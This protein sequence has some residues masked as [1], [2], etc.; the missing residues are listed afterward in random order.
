MYHIILPLKKLQ[1]GYL[2]FRFGGK[3]VLG[4]SMFLAS[5]FTLVVPP[6]ARLSYIALFICRLIVGLCH[7]SSC[8]ENFLYFIKRNYL[9]NICAKWKGAFW[10]AV[11][12]IWSQWAPTA[13]RRSIVV[14]LKKCILQYFYRIFSTSVTVLHRILPHRT[15]P[16][17]SKNT[18]N[19]FKRDFF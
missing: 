15:V 12:T 4:S 11:S 14:E 17:F 10:P 8:R 2:S 19:I 18:K 16:S 13:E 9:F 5:V 6:C 1:G 3:L 7:V